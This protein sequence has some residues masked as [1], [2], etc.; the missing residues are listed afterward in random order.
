MK[1]DRDGFEAFL[2]LM[3]VGILVAS[4]E[5]NIIFQNDLIARL[6]GIDA[7]EIL[8]KGM[9]ALAGLD[10]LTASWDGLRNA[11]LGRETIVFRQGER[12][13]SAN[14]CRGNA[15]L[16]GEPNT[17]LVFS[18]FTEYKRMEELKSGLI[19]NIVHRVKGP[20]TSVTTSLA[21][22]AANRY[23]AIPPEAQEL[24]SL[25]YAEVQRMGLILTDAADLIS[26]ETG[27]AATGLYIENIPLRD[28]LPN[29]LSDFEKMSTG[30]KPA[31]RIHWEG[32]E[33]AE[34]LGDFEKLEQML[35]QVLA[36]AAG[37]EKTTTT[38]TVTV[39]NAGV[40][41][42]EIVIDDDGPALTQE[43]L[44]RIF[45]KAAPPA[46]GRLARTGPSLYSAKKYAALMGGS[47]TLESTGK[48]GAKATIRLRSEGGGI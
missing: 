23:V 46:F 10:D 17:I 20:L 18:D 41:G 5:G 14:L 31:I 37:H 40:D 24:V 12:E 36:N 39:R 4:D 30:N 3:P 6:L 33:H 26:L 38:I 45:D 28:F 13:L 1:M 8:Q 25:S 43:E 7:L 9:S 42:I 21:L 22:L 11:R 2:N 27:A 19:N 16:F 32:G 15:E 44:A 35:F 34:V 29:L 48:V 47:L